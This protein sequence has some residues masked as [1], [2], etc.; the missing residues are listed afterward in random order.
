MQRGGGG[1]LSAV[2]SYTTAKIIIK[3]GKKTQTTDNVAPIPFFSPHLPA[4]CVERNFPTPRG[5]F[6][7]GT[8]DQWL[9]RS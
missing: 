1:S 7:F 9:R 8:D 6:P 4:W 3:T 5:E 2:Y